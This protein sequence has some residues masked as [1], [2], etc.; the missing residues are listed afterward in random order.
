MNKVTLKQAINAGF[1][2]QPTLDN[3]IGLL[4]FRKD[5]DALIFNK[6]EDIISFIIEELQ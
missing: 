4:L 2:I 5:R 1:K 3:N 6:F